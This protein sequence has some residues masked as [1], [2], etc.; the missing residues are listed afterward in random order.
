MLEER[1]KAAEEYGKDKNGQEKSHN[2]I[3]QPHLSRFGPIAEIPPIWPGQ[4]K[5]SQ[6]A[7]D[8][9]RKSDDTLS[10]HISPHSP[11]VTGLHRSTRTLAIK[12]LTPDGKTETRLWFVFVGAIFL[13]VNADNGFCLRRRCAH[14]SG[15]N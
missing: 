7:K 14:C 8:C 1:R 4:S 3:D 12:Q 15:A 5:A 10:R 11:D 2:E 6:C 13:I 9:K